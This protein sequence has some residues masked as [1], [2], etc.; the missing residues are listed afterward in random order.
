MLGRE[1]FFRELPSIDQHATAIETEYRSRFNAAAQARTKAYQGALNTLQANAAWPELNEEQQARV[2]KPLATRASGDVPGSATISF[3]RAECNACAQHLKSA[4]R[5][6]LELI[7][8]AR[9]VTINL[10]DFFS[11]RVETPEQLEA[12]LASLRQRVEKLLGEGKK[13][14]IH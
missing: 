12:S 8:G 3:L 10:G 2:A 5:E 7:E 9:L 13:V 4:I 6:M 1:T 11:G 14:L